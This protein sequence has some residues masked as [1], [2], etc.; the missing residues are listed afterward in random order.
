MC[1]AT[2]IED[3]P[4]PEKYL[5]DVYI[6]DF[7]GLTIPTMQQQLDHVTNG[8]MFGIHKVFLLEK[9]FGRPLLLKKLINKDAK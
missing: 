5:L 1:K 7:I 6:I 4:I 9:S 8:I 2:Y 3:D